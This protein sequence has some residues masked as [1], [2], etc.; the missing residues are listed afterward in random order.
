M[1]E[2]R[3]VMIAIPRI[4]MDVTQR[5]Q[6]SLAGL[7]LI[8]LQNALRIAVMD[9]LLLV[10]SAMTTIKILE[11]AAAVLARQR[12]AGHALGLHLPV[13]LFVEIR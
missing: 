10:N 4:M 8:L 2:T 11:M 5:V 3:H 13:I 7:A 9:K 6:Q 1:L 12:L